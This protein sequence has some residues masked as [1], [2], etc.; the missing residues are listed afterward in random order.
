[1][2]G[3][4]TPERTL[5]TCWTNMRQ[6][7]NNPNCP[8]YKHYGG[9][10]ITICA[11]WSCFNN[12]LNDMLPTWVRGLEIDRKRNDEG[13]S[14]SNCHWDTHRNNL[15]NRR[16]WKVDP[17]YYSLASARRKAVWAAFTKKERVAIVAKQVR[18]R[19]ESQAKKK[20]KP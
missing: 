10:G 16:G 14:P 5:Y 7:C 18:A 4:L 12:F 15:L 9:R 13:Y 6:R 20:K 11:R 3:H 1:M 2:R 19:A 17:K 8:Q